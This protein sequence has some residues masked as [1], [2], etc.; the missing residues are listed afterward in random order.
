MKQKTKKNLYI[1]T[2]KS[3]FIEHH[4]NIFRLKFIEFSSIELYYLKLNEI[5]SNWSSIKHG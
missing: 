4:E 2:H 3:V 5:F 1:A